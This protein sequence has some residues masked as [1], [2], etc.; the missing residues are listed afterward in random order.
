MRVAFVDLDRMHADP[1]LG[2]V[3]DSAAVSG[4]KVT[5][6]ASVTTTT[7]GHVVIGLRH[8]LMACNA[9]VS[10]YG[11]PD[12]DPSKDALGILNAVPIHPP[13][14]DAGA[15]PAFSARVRSVLLAQAAFVRDVITRADGTVANGATIANGKA[16]ASTDPAT[17]ESQA[18]AVRVLIE[19]FFLTQDTSYRDRARAVAVHLLTSFYSAPA[20]MFRGTDGG[21]DDV[22]MTA[23]RFAW[24]QSALRETYKFFW[25]QGDPVLGRDV[26]EDRIARIGKLYLNGWD[27]LNGDGTVQKQGECLDARMQMGEQALTGELGADSNGFPGSSSSDRD[28]DCVLNISGGKLASVLAGEVHFHSP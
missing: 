20:R 2:V 8:L 15:P 21:P 16:T 19:A 3:V 7:L 11:A 26:L 28:A 4:G 12:P 17:L 24:L 10:Q 22:H 18:A 14:A 25:V 13:V 27:D 23:E 5:R 9:G 1:A 6:G